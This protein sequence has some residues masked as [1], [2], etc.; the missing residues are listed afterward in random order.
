MVMRNCH[1]VMGSEGYAG[2]G[3]A[4]IVVLLS[5]LHVCTMPLLG[6]LYLGS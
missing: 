6:I 3:V 4:S 1:R 5:S 2:V